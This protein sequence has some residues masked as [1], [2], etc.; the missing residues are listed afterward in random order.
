MTEYLGIEI[1]RPVVTWN[2]VPTTSFEF[3]RQLLEFEGTSHE[4]TPISTETPHKFSFRASNFSKSE[5]KEL[6]DFFFSKKGSLRRFWFPLPMS[7]FSTIQDPPGTGQFKLLN[8]NFLGREHIW[9]ERN[10]GDFFTTQAQH[11][12][13]EEEDYWFVNFGILDLQARAIG[14]LILAR[15]ENDSLEITHDSCDI[16][17]TNIGIIELVNE[18]SEL[19]D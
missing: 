14:L 16:S 3:E 5:E 17:E 13:D 12:Q 4:L 7:L 1:W 19:G 15:F 18:Y 9:L 2:T 10:N 6:I 11:Y 8:Y